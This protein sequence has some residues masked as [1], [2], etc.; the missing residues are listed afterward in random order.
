MQNPMIND[1]ATLI[2][3][4]ECRASGINSRVTR[5]IIAPAANPIRT[6]MMGW[7]NHETYAAGTAAIGW[8]RLVKKAAQKHFQI[9]APAARIGTATASPSGIL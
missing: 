4:E 1:H 6:G 7:N 9:D 8:G 3:I 5:K 2:G